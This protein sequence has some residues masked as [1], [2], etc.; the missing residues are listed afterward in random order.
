MA[1]RFGPEPVAQSCCEVMGFS[2]RFSRRF[3]G[4]LMGFYFFCEWMLTWFICQPRWLS[5]TTTKGCLWPLDAPE[6]RAPMAA[7]EGL[8]TPPL[9]IPW[10]LAIG[11]NTIRK[12][13][14]LWNM[15]WLPSNWCRQACVFCLQPPPSWCHQLII[16]GV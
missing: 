12:P 6:Q 14:A 16:R 8:F 15:P 4:R 9:P 11:D 7:A 13:S 2:C 5:T 3:N 1:E 10:S